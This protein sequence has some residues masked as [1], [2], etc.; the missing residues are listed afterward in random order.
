MSDINRLVQEVDDLGILNIDVS[1]DGQIS[2]EVIKIAIRATKRL[3]TRLDKLVIAQKLQEVD[4]I[5]AA[6]YR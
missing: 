6:Q 2:S 3:D 4:R 5:V 1:G